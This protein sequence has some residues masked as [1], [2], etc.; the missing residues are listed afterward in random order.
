MIVTAE[1]FVPG[2]EP[3]MAPAPIPF[4]RPDASMVFARRAQRLRDLA[5][6]HP[7][8]DFLAFIAGLADIQHD[9]AA[10]AMEW[11][12]ALPALLDRAAATPAPAAV[13]NAIHGL[14]SESPAEITGRAER[15]LSGQ[16]RPDDLAGAPFMVAALQIARTQ[17]AATALPQSSGGGCCLLCGGAPVAATIATHK[18]V[19]GVRY[20]HCGLCATAWH[21][22]RLRCP[23]CHSDGKVTY[24]R[25]D[26]Y[27]IEVKAETCADCGTYVKVF[28]TDDCP[29][30]EPLADD[31][32]SVALDLYMAEE[33]WRR[34]WPNPF[35][36]GA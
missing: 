3:G 4:L 29:V 1:D 10:T 23:Q 32:S 5:S 36:H 20:L 22:E 26:G 9:L 6:G 24:R 27:A 19:A 28:Y 7:M 11:Q 16:P 35:L 15:W 2:Q 14:R 25:L 33:S 12:V 8:A 13:Q 21:L 17:A 18:G 31:L 34:L 30:V